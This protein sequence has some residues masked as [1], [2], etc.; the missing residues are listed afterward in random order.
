[1]QSS[2][3]KALE[4]DRIV[5]AVGRLAQTPPGAGR[6]ARLQPEADGRAVAAALAATAE[7]A[8]F[9]GGS[10]EIALR[11]P[12]DL[13]ATLTH[14]AVE[15]RALEALSLLALATFLGS[16]ET[17]ATGIRPP[18]RRFRSWA[19]WRRRR[20]R[21]SASS[22]TSAGRSI[23]SG[24]VVDDASPELRSI[25]DRLRKQKA[26][27]RGTLESYLRGK[28]TAKYL[29]QQIVTDRNGRYVL[30]VRSEHRSGDTRH[31]ARQLGERREPVPRAAQHR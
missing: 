7:T 12:E 21:S 14:L 29:Q 1:M 4:F 13:D 30:V 27:L 9:L 19:P 8:R 16:I 23:P 18:A 22:R 3:L 20:R 11:A 10:G 6:L 25:R 5:E 2:A 24:D 26:R 17:T 15:G 28:D 31:R